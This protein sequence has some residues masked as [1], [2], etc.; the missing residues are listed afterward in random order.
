MVSHGITLTDARKIVR[1]IAKIDPEE[2][3]EALEKFDTAYK[4]WHTRVNT[5]IPET[6]K[7]EG[8]STNERRY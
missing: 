1:Y 3:I 8:G 6:S 4:Q 7:G 5:R 2:N